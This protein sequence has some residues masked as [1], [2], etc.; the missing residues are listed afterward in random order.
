MKTTALR[1][2]YERLLDAAATPHLGDAAGGGWNA[3]QILAHLLSLDAGIAAVALGVVSGSRPTF[4]NR[5]SL[6]TWNLNRII[7]GHSGRAELID[8]VRS[9]A[10]VLCDIADQLNE[11]AAS[12]LVP[13]LLL[14]ND[15]LMLDQP[16]PLAG[17]ID[18]L[19]ENHVPVHTQQLLDLRAAVPGNT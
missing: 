19:A 3:D 6:D 18:G 12:V 17:L 13:S 10:T 1:S 4:D 11:K 9:Q 15:A 8:H 7:A 16:I 14:S 5:I 2:A